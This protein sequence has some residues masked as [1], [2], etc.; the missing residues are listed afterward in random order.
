MSV[1]RD[2][3]HSGG[4]PTI[5]GTGIRVQDIAEAYVHSGYEPDEIIELYPDLGLADVH[6]ALAYYYDH[7]DDFRSH[8]HAEA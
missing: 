8:P 5:Q 2:E 3:D 1:V 7:A 4:A 6:A